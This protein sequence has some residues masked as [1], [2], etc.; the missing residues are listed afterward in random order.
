MGRI[1]CNMSADDYAKLTAAGELIKDNEE[2][3]GD[4]QFAR[5]GIVQA[6]IACGLDD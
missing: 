5:S 1:L 3:F 2:W 6:R 4:A